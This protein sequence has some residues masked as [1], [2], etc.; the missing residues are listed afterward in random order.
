[1]IPIYERWIEFLESL[2]PELIGLQWIEHK[3]YVQREIRH[4]KEIIVQEQI[5]EILRG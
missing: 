2:L 4:V 5:E 1:M 3:N